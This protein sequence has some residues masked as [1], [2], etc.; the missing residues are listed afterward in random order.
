MALA[1]SQSRMLVAFIVQNQCEQ[2]RLS[3]ELTSAPASINALATAPVLASDN[4]VL[5][6]LSL[7]SMSKPLSVDSFAM[8]SLLC[9]AASDS[10]VSPKFLGSK[11]RPG[12]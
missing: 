5:P 4:D 8:L 7:A 2:P 11:S 12:Y 6:L 3:S 1:L 9:L 10:G